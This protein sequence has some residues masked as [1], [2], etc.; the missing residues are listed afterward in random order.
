[1]NKNRVFY[2]FAFGLTLSNPSF[3]D[4]ISLRADPWC[5]HTC[6]P[7]THQNGILVDIAKTIFEEAGHTIE[8]SVLNWARAIDQTREGKFNGVVGAYSSDAPDFIFPSVA[9]GTTQNCFFVKSESSF[10]YS[11][12]ESLNGQNVGVVAGYSYGEP[13]DTLIQKS[14]GTDPKAPKFETVTGN[15]ALA[16]NF[17]KLFAGRLNAVLEEKQVEKFGISKLP[18]FKGSK[19]AGCLNPQQTFIA[20]SPHPSLKE[21][22]KKYA[23]ILSQG[24]AKI[25]KNGK[26]KAILSKYYH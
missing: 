16:M 3:S 22:S 14:T 9:Q 15:D 21:K 5:P 26:L 13:I 12:P 19:S 4:T 2:V 11:K 8:Y 18:E 17:K 24:M 23:E 1:M 7:E 10:K 6:D 20:F 25:K